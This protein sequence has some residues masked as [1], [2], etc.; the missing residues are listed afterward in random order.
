MKNRLDK[1]QLDLTNIIKA[2]RCI[3]GNLDWAGFLFVCF[4]SRGFLA[5]VSRQI[6]PANALLHVQDKQNLK[7]CQ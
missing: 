7:I 1:Q 2:L 3:A 4:C 6:N 5:G